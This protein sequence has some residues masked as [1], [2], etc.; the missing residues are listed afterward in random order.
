MVKMK[1]VVCYG[2]DELK[3][4]EIPKPKIEK[5][6]QVLVGVK[7]A[8]VCGSDFALFSGNE[9]PW[10]R[11][12]VVPGHEVAGVVV[13]IG[14]KVD[15]FHRDDAVVIDN[16]LRCGECYY[17]KKGDYFHCESYREIGFT[18][19]GGFAEFC[20]VPKTN[21]FLVPEGLDVK[22]ALLAEPTATA[23][24]A[25]RKANIRFTDTIVVL[26][27]GPLGMLLLAVAKSMG[28][29]KV[30]LVG[31]GERIK[32][33]QGIGADI[34]IDSSKENWPQ[35]VLEKNEG[36][37]VDSVL[38]ATGSTE[39]IDPAIKIVKEGGTIILLGITWG[40]RV[41]FSVDKMVIKEVGL[42]SSIAG[43]GCFEEALALLEK[44]KVNPC[45]IITHTF[46][47]EE[48]EKAL[49]YERKRVEGAIKVRI[50]P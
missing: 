26:G 47:L 14:S 46:P 19:N 8:G 2:K 43:V 1:A 21:L 3:L 7:A 42:I 50:I 5:P 32:H 28:A 9:S 12:P 37:K 11:Y 4:Q 24:R 30:I 6:D 49:Q 20:L 27:C 33:A 31:R 36:A 18:I 45:K 39:I 15:E 22:D 34:I 44:R 23:I 41:S 13:D 40:R 10:S 48:F 29:A 17:C 25:C 16:Y 35:R 38:E